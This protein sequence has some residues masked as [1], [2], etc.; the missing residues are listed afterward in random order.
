MLREGISREPQNSDAMF[1][2]L[3]SVSYKNNDIFILFLRLIF[4]QSILLDTN[5][6]VGGIKVAHV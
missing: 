4:L 5:E 2:I 1:K 3:L 6:P